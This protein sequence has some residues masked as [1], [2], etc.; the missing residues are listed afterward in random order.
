MHPREF[1]INDKPLD[2][3]PSFSSPY[4]AFNWVGGVIYKGEIGKGLNFRKSIKRVD[5]MAGPAE[6]EVRNM[7]VGVVIF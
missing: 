3:E 1:G 6:M 2:E 5:T 7:A 4:R